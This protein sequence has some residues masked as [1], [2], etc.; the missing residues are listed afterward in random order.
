MEILKQFGI[1]IAFAFIGEILHALIPLPVPA[2]IYGILLLFVF[3]RKKILHVIQVR[4]TVHFLI[5][6]MP[7]M[8]VPA[9]AG[10][11]DAWDLIRPQLI[12]YLVMI[13]VSLLVVM[14]VSGLTTQFIIRHQ[15]KT[16]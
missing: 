10:L 8:F 5:E 2:G 4:E 9:A 6:T 3:L 1:I 7:I 14:V 13:I 16:T 15:K 12:P 11:I